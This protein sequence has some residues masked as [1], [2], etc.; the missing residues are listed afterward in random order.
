MGTPRMS[1][2]DASRRSLLAKCEVTSR[3]PAVIADCGVV[4]GVRV[5]EVG[6]PKLRRGTPTW[7][8]L[9]ENSTNFY[10]NGKISEDSSGWGKVG[11]LNRIN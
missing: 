9:I 5:I 8:N 6:E 7:G 4:Q 3:V 11:K 10:P 1:T 2:V